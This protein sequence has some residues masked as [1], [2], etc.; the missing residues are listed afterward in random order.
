VTTA[1]DLADAVNTAWQAPAGMA[2][3]TQRAAAVIAAAAPALT[4]TRDALLALLPD[5]THATT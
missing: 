4:T 2:E 1:A 3:K 5:P